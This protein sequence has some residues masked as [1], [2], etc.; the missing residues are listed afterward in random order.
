MPGL[1]E[2]TLFGLDW[3]GKAKLQI[4]IAEEPENCRLV[5][6]STGI[7]EPFTSEREYQALQDANARSAAASIIKGHQAELIRRVTLTNVSLD[8]EESGDQSPIIDKVFQ[9]RSAP[10]EAKER[11]QKC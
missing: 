4:H 3:M 1:P 10:S 11:D 9:Q 7:N 8:E 2:Q 6:E 5:S